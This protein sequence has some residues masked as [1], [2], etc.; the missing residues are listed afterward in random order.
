M[1]TYTVRFY[2][3]SPFSN[4]ISA[5]NPSSIYTG[6]ADTAFEAVITDTQSG[7]QG[8]TLSEGTEETA[9]ALVTRL[10][11]G[12]EQGRLQ[13]SAVYSYSVRDTVT[14]EEFEIIRL[15]VHGV[16]ELSGS[17]YTLSE[18]PL[19]PGRTYDLLASD[20]TPNAAAG[21]PVFTYS[22]YVCL[23]D[24][25]PIDT[26]DG[27]RAVEDLRPGDRVLTLDSG[28]QEIVWAGSRQ[29]A[30]PPGPHPH[31]PILLPEG[32]L[33][34]GRPWRDIAVSPQHRILLR[35]GRGGELLGPAKGLLPLPG[36][37]A[38]NG[39]RAVVYRS[40]AL[41]AH[42]IVRAAGAAVET[43]WPGEMALALLSAA[44]R[45]ALEALFP[46]IL[47]GTMAYGDP[48]RPLATVSTTLA[49]ARAL[50]SSG[51]APT[52]APGRAADGHAALPKP[53]AAAKCAVNI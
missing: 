42:G 10:S 13:V 5:V 25:T 34:S 35:D 31:K 4:G 28:A 38:L 53:A 29:L 24:G 2:A 30:F 12:L 18:Q 17:N 41:A 15:R 51:L 23:A 3:G 45:A 36:V 21:D 19:V 47:S 48:A 49:I 32:C 9:N 14:C 27:P 33:G 46:G 6:P 16:D 22:D 50:R 11:D 8:L 7:I 1:S 52:E 40:F 37:R 26:P 44:E 39:R 20:S 43:L